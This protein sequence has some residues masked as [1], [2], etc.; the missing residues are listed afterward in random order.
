M[1]M[2][3]NYYIIG[4]RRSTLVTAWNDIASGL[5][6]Y[7]VWLYFGWQDILQ[8][9]RR[10]ILG[11]FWVTITTGVM[12]L[13]MSMLYG[14]LLNLPLSEYVPFLA[15]GIIIWN[16]IISITNDGCATFLSCD[17]MIKQLRMPLSFYVCRMLWRN[18]I[19]FFHNIILFIPIWLIFGC[20]IKLLDLFVLTISIIIFFLNSFWLGL[21]LG[22]FHTRFRDIGPIVGSIMQVIFF[23]TPIMWLPSLLKSKGIA[24]YLIIAN[25]IYHFV[26]IM[27][28]PLL[29]KGELISS[30]SWLI[31]IGVTFSGLLFSIFILGKFKHR[32]AYW[33]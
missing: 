16:L 19:V 7:R 22:F 24:W 17:A 9:Y 11:P 25:P 29:G 26:E 2:S 31:V 5:Y 14:K 27:R 21:I 13:A 4:N 33:L 12:I 18:I 8:R 3:D 1:G 30:L 32:L 23:L 6:Y 10:S 20:Q 28:E 15:A